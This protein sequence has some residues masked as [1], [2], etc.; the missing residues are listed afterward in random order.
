MVKT[1]FQ[2]LIFN[3]ERELKV[4]REI[5]IPFRVVVWL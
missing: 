1:H 4:V 3:Y 5:T 2:I